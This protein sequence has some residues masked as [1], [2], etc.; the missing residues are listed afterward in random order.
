MS[1]SQYSWRAAGVVGSL[2]LLGLAGWPILPDY[3]EPEVRSYLLCIPASVGFGLAC[4]R[5]PAQGDR[6]FGWVGCLLGGGL[7]VAFACRT[8]YHLGV[9]PLLM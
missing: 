4:F 5:S 6:L 2:L 9:L 8:L 7:L 1:E 3:Y